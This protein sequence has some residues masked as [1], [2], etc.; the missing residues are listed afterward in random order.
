MKPLASGEIRGTWATLL[1]PIAPD[2]QIDFARLADEID[3]LVSTEVDGIYSNG[4]AGEFH[5]QSED[6]FDR[7]NS[8]FAE[9]CERAGMPFQIG[10]SHMSAQISIERLKRAIQWH[11]SAIQVILP[12]WV[13]VSNDEAIAFL[14]RTE[15]IAEPAGLVLYNPPHAKRVLDPGSIAQLGAAVPAIVGVK[16]ADGNASWY[17]S[18]RKHLLEL[19]VFVPGHHLAT[20]F[21]QGASG[22]YSNVACISPRGAKQ[23][24]DLMQS[25]LPAALDIERRVLSFFQGHIAPLSSQGYSNPALD[26]LLAAIGGWSNIGT[27]LRFPYRAIPESLV[28]ELREIAQQMIPELFVF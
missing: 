23:W 2:D 16:I 27:R 11:P 5:A 20:G 15:E 28:V 22:S 24:W 26:K 21:Q 25:D 17:A 13:P 9:K 14:R 6:E 10:V 7:V 4:T 3:Y 1:L 8:L 19:S 12:D 18:V